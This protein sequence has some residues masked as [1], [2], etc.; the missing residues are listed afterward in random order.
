MNPILVRKLGRDL[1]EHWTQFVAV[2]LMAMLSVLIF[3]GLEGGWRGIQT[4]LDTFADE[5][6][7]P[8]GWLTGLGLTGADAAAVAAVDGVRAAALVTTV[9]LVHLDAGERHALT[10]STSS[11]PEINLPLVV[12]GQRFTQGDGIWLDEAYARANGV[13]A[14]DR[15]ALARGGTVTE[16]TVRGLILLPDR[17]AYTGAGLVAPEPASFGYGLV[18]DATA[19]ALAGSGPAQQT[20]QVRGDLGRLRDE[21]AAL[22]G[23]RYRSLADRTTYP[24]VATAYERAD[25]IRTLSYL[26]SSL[27]LLVALLSI[28][29]SVRRLTDTQRSEIAT[30]KALG[31]ANRTIG[32]YY[33]AV[34][35]VV[36]AVGCLAGLAATPALSRYVLATQRGS[37]SLP[38][39]VPA[40]TPASAFLPGLLLGVCVL[41]S[42]SATR[43]MRVLTPAE[44]MRP[45]T[46]RARHTAVERVPGVWRRLSY[47][48]RWAVRDA[49]GSPVRVSMGLVAMVGCM[50]L[51]VAGFGMP[52]TLNQQVRQSYGEQYRYAARLD[53]VP[54]AGAAARERIREEAG[55]GQ[56]VQQ[57][58]ARVGRDGTPE[59]ERAVTVL[60]EGDLFR[61]LGPDGRPVPLGSGA[62]V[63]DR[64]ADQLGLA[65]GSRVFVRTADG[66]TAEF[67]VSAV[68]IVSEPQGVLVGE[69]AWRDAGGVVAP[70][71]YLTEHAVGPGVTEL[72]G[73]LTSITRAEQRANA[74]ALVDSLASVFRLIKAFAVVL[75]VVVLYNLGALSFTERIRDY[76]TLRVL[77]FRLRELRSLASR[78]NGFTTVLGWGAGIPA[79]WWFLGEYVALFSNDRAMYRPSVEPTSWIVASAI[80][81]L[82]AMTATLLLTRRIRSVDMT[83][84]LK[85]VE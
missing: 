11:G 79:G 21:A 23:Q 49:A 74:Q 7:M 80:T 37:F 78:E 84:A 42:W 56:W 34:G 73:V 71:G 63:T 25:Q 12:E 62:V 46:G 28:F 33:T 17:I 1:R 27:F 66:T 35:S 65:V 44:G 81:I 30:L 32:G 8:D 67:P 13:A 52:D 60:G 70:T 5:H 68:T 75:A 48:A 16:L 38:A 76:A 31:H 10:V 36:V 64:V 41:A 29:T 14:G 9:P 77:G 83:S 39:W 54:T 85:G 18:S 22:L 72:P 82:S 58:P 2:G 15:V 20:I 69:R 40:Y 4:E 3:S 53:I 24:Y 43:P 55:P 59:L 47:G 51:L 61:V 45:D 6:R 26:F 50:M 19:R 57:T